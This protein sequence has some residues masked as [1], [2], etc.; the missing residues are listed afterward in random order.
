MIAMRVWVVWSASCCLAA[1]RLA[2]SHRTCLPELHVHANAATGDDDNLR[3]IVATAG[4]GRDGEHPTATAAVRSLDAAQA[5]VRAHRKRCPSSQITVHLAGRFEIQA[6]LL[7]GPDDSGTPERPVIWRAAKSASPVLSGGVSVSSWTKGGSVIQ[8]DGSVSG[9]RWTAPLPEV[10]RTPGEQLPNSLWLGGN[11][12]HLAR[13]PAPTLDP[14]R[15]GEYNSLNWVQAVNPDNHTADANKWGVIVRTADLPESL[16]VAGKPI[17]DNVYFTLFHSYDTSSCRIRNITHFHP[18]HTQPKGTTKCCWN[19]I[20]QSCNSSTQCDPGG[21]G[22]VV[23]GTLTKKYGPCNC[24]TCASQGK[25]YDPTTSSCKP[26]ERDDGAT[27][28]HDEPW[29]QVN[30][31]N[32]TSEYISNYLTDSHRRYYISNV[33]EGLSTAGVFLVRP[34]H[35]TLVAPVGVDPNREGA[36]AGHLIS[37]KVLDGA[38]HLRFDRLT[39]RHLDWQGHRLSVSSSDGG[40]SWPANDGAAMNASGAIRVA[41]AVGINI[42]HCAFE[43]LGGSALAIGSNTQNISLV[44]SQMADSAIGGVYMD[45]YPTVGAKYGEGGCGGIYIHNNL[46]RDGGHVVPQGVGIHISGCSNVT[47]QRNDISSFHGKGIVI[48]GSINP[49]SNT[50]MEYATVDACARP[51]ACCENLVIEHNYIHDLVNGTLSDKAFIQLWGAGGSVERGTRTLIQ[52]NTL[53]DLY[54]FNPGNGAGMYDDS[55]TTQVTWRQNIV[56]HCGGTG[57]HFRV[58]SCLCPCKYSVPASTG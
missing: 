42:T 23:S 20:I 41:N 58:L 12:Y 18:N 33:L 39:Y 45:G 32:P 54:T 4:D 44:S 11:R 8:R 25:V 34:A 2:S 10:Y 21:E 30:F 26:H 15:H 1:S 47:V 3:R 56:W 7:L 49:Y 52:R 19:R 35:I 51:Y 37:V 22:C 14:D 16:L 17:P 40:G 46:L 43:H 50:S 29:S 38:S 36:I 28:R 5:A 53:H 57:V 27:S 9:V 55:F 13:L 31:A 48:R 24:H 6:P